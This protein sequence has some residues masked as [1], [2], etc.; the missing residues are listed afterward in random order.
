MAGNHQSYTRP[1]RR[2]IILVL[3]LMLSVVLSAC[4]GSAQ[5][6]TYTIGVVN[7]VPA[8]EQVFAGFKTRMTELGYVEGNNV[9]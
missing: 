6:K 5:P 9:V 1:L 3:T 7:Y 4:S 8:L 2:S